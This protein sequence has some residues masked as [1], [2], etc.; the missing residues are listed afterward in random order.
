[1]DADYSRRQST[2]QWPRRGRWN[3][4]ELPAWYLDLI[5]AVAHDLMAWRLHDPGQRLDPRCDP[6]QPRRHQSERRAIR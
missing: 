1:M 3:P 4:D 5:G 6:R 2:G